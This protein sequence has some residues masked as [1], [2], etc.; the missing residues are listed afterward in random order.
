MIK[1]GEEQAHVCTSTDCS[2]YG[3][4]SVGFIVRKALGHDEHALGAGA[5]MGAVGR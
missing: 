1:V 2:S 4:L 3:M 5:L